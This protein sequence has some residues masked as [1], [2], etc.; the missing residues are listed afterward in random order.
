VSTPTPDEI[1]IG[2]ALKNAPVHD[3]L[4]EG[5]LPTDAFDEPTP[6]RIWGLFRDYFQKHGD[7][8]D[9]DLLQDLAT[10]EIPDHA[11]DIIAYARRARNAVEDRNIDGSK[12]DYY[13]RRLL[14]THEDIDLRRKLGSAIDILRQEGPTACLDY[15]QGATTVEAAITD[16]VK[17]TDLVEDFEER[18]KDVLDRRE[19]PQESNAIPL[20]IEPIDRV[21]NG[22][23]LGGELMVFAA[24]PGGG[25]SVSLM[26]VAISSAEQ[27]RKVHFFT[28]EMGLV[29]TAFRGYSRMSGVSTKHFRNAEN[30]TDQD[31]EMWRA[32]VKKLRQVAGA[33]VKITSIPEH[34]SVRFMRAELARLERKEGWKPDLILVDYAGIMRPSG[35]GQYKNESDWAYVGQ[36]VKDLKVWAISADIPVIS[37]VQLL[38]DAIGKDSLTF[39]DLGLSKIL[40]AA[41]CDVIV[42]FIPLSPEELEFVEILTL[43][44]QWLKAREGTE[45]ENGKPVLFTD[46]TPNFSEIRI[47]APSGAVA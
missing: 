37:A 38:P 16:T 23:L 32:S 13:I 30:I 31:L 40:I 46:L 1:L 10:Q 28:I 42:A 35:D 2:S 7:I 21:L 19:N 18:E 33:G 14:D 34:A 9:L 27:G 8:P 39:K 3:Y 43:R 12:I 41:T 25:K 17:T 20:G 24:I 5:G 36:N 29:Q 26:D 45:D 15:L 47:H 6:H 11:D 44:L 4:D 22:G